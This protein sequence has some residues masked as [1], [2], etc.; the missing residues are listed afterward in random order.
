MIKVMSESYRL[1]TIDTAFISKPVH[2]DIP[3]QTFGGIDLNS[4]R[5]NVPSVYQ[6]GVE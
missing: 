4:L 1:F 6:M 2:D 3:N 5:P